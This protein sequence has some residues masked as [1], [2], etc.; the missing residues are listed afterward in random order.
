MPDI[1]SPGAAG[2]VVLAGLL[3]DDREGREDGDEDQWQHTDCR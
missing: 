3:T 2:N 1:D